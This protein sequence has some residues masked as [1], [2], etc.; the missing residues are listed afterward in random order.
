[1]AEPPS[2]AEH[3]RFPVSIAIPR[4]R[5]TRTAL[6]LAFELVVIF[7]GVYAASSVAKYEERRATVERRHQIRLALMREIEG[8]TMNT[9]RVARTLGVVTAGYDSAIAAGGTPPLQPVIDPV[10]VE[11]HM[12]EATLQSGGLDLLDV[13]TVYRLSEF[14]NNLNGGFEQLAQLRS[15]SESLL[16][17]NLDRG[18]EEFYA[19]GGKGHRPKYQWYLSGMRQLR[20]RAEHITAQGD[21]L[22]ADLRRGDAGG[23]ARAPLVAP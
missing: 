6:R 19:P 4:E 14:Y 5:F 17:P 20:A 22:L 21:S 13:P 15:L 18:P 16:L 2:P 7:F 3:P 9:R 1:V 12:W 23:R 8:I 11:A 10:R